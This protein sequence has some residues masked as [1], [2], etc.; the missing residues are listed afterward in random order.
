VLIVALLSTGSFAQSKEQDSSSLIER[1]KQL[2]DIRAEGAPAFRLKANFKSTHDDGSTVE[3]V[4]TETWVSSRLWR[5]EVISG[6]LHQTEVAKDRTLW[7]LSNFPTAPDAM[8]PT[9][10]NA[11]EHLVA[12]HLD[13]NSLPS[14]SWKTAKIE[15]RS[16]GS[17]SLRCIVPNNQFYG[18]KDELC[19]DT[20]NGTLVARSNPVRLLTTGRVFESTCTYTDYQK[21]GEKVFPRS[22]QCAAGGK[23]TLQGTVVELT[24]AEASPD[25]SLFVPLPGARELPHCPWATKHV[26]AVQQRDPAFPSGLKEPS[27]PVTLSLTVGVDGK[28]RD[29]RVIRSAG[30][31]FDNS[32]MEAVK[33]WQFRPATCGGEPMESEITAEI[34][35]HRYD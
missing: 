20:A 9:D 24:A 18:G 21:F 26:E 16:S 4:Y 6:D 11:P 8:G 23:Q 29:L 14:E 35:F 12:F 33:K 25:P 28:P 13:D 1:A 7:L 5:S 17:W 3:A 10:A 32:A 31:G 15:D 2:S 19:F 30:E 27:N 22:I 34:V